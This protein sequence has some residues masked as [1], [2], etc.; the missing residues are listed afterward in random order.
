MKGG[1]QERGMPVNECKEVLS[2]V[3]K[4]SRIRLW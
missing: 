3:L 4:D 1:E 2:G